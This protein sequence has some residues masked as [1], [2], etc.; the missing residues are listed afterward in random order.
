MVNADG[1]YDVPEQLALSKEP[2]IP[3]LEPYFPGGKAREPLNA[4]EIEKLFQR[5]EAYREE[6]GCYWSSTRNNTGTGALQYCRG[7]LFRHNTT[8]R[9]LRPTD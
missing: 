6:Y 4:I 9:F 8:N 3:E 1:N 5:L 2:F 7:L